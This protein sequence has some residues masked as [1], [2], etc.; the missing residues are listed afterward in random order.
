MTVYLR[1]TFKYIFQT[2]LHSTIYFSRF[3][4]SCDVGANYPHHFSTQISYPI[5]YDA[6]NISTEIVDSTTTYDLPRSGLDALEGCYM[7]NVVTTGTH[8]IYIHMRYTYKYYI[9]FTFTFY[10]FI[11]VWKLCLRWY[12]VPI[13][14]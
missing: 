10:T 8:S 1:V 13:L 2:T 5:S 3:V 11:H 14:L 7:Q 6:N 9:L 4:N 12:L